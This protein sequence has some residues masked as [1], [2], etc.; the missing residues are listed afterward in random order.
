MS[1]TV[2]V[3]TWAKKYLGVCVLLLAM[4]YAA[5]RVAYNLSLIHI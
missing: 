1:W 2:H 4:A 3:M 5:I